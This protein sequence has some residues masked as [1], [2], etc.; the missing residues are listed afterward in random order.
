MI[1]LSKTSHLR[2]ATESDFRS[3]EGTLIIGLEYYEFMMGTRTWDRQITDY[4]TDREWLKSKIAFGY[5]KMNPK[6]VYWNVKSID[7][8][9]EDLANLELQPELYEQ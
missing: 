4:L 2:L 9:L 1:S 3:S 5:I 7:L 8:L 6:P